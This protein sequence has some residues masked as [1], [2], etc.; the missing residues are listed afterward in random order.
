MACVCYVVCDDNDNDDHSNSTSND[1]N[2]THSTVCGSMHWLLLYLF[3]MWDIIISELTHFI[4]TATVAVYI[5]HFIS[6]VVCVCVCACVFIR[7]LS[8]LSSA[9]LSPCSLFIH[10]IFITI[11]FVQNY[12]LFFISSRHLTYVTIT[13]ISWSSAH[14]H[15]QFSTEWMKYEVR[16][17]WRRRQSYTWA[18]KESDKNS[19]ERW[20]WERGRL[21]VCSSWKRWRERENERA[22]K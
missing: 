6:L 2:Q 18:N 16:R 13:Q 20:W 19:Y 7:F 22:K 3:W 15:W 12:F 1:L 14:I 9:I 8:L 17:E 10:F 5:F 21:Y 4:C 11:I